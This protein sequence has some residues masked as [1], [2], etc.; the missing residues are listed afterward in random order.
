[1][2]PVMQLNETAISGYMPDL[3]IFINVPPERAFLRM[4]EHKEHDRLECEDIS[5]HRR[6][7]DGFT[8]LAGSADVLS[9]EAQGTQI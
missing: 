7:F 6:V 1:M 9:I 2:E 5:F 3:T 8:A 4:N